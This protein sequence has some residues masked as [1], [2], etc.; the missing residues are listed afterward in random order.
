MPMST[1]IL[2]GVFITH[3]HLDHIGDLGALVPSGLQGSNVGLPW[4]YVPAIVPA[5]AASGSGFPN[6]WLK[7][8]ATHRDMFS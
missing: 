2:G 3:T 8:G 6:W 4:L 5:A 7:A 1:A